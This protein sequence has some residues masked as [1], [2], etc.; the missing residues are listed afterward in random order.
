MARDDLTG[1]H[2][3]NPNSPAPGNSPR[4]DHGDLHLILNDGMQFRETALVLR[5]ASYAMRELILRRRAKATTA[6]RPAEWL[7]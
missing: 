3:E 7:G 2:H 5:F 4:A 6:R 1:S